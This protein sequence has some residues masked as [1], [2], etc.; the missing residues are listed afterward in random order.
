M[1][2][3]ACYFLNKMIFTNIQDL[4]FHQEIGSLLL[5]IIC[6]KILFL[7]MIFMLKVLTIQELKGYI[8]K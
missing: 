2:A 3:V 4:N 5:V 7:G 1:M 6:C 8:Q